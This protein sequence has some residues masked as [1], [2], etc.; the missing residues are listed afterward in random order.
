M[1]K[2]RIVPIRGA[3]KLFRRSLRQDKIQKTEKVLDALV[4]FSYKKAL[5][6]EELH[7]KTVN[8]TSK[9]FLDALAAFRAKM[10]LAP[11]TQLEEEN[12]KET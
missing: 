6:F 4:R 8:K 11:R 1:A 3:E 7:L 2:A 9:K 10:P 12:E 5:H